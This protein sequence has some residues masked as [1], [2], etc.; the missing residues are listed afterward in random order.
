[1]RTGSVGFAAAIDA[2]ERAKGRKNRQIQPAQEYQREERNE[3]AH[4]APQRRV[5][6][7]IAGTDA[8]HLNEQLHGAAFLRGGLLA[9]G[10][11]DVP[12]KSYVASLHYR[13]QRSP[14][15]NGKATQLKQLPLMLEA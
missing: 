3:D 15:W 11:A 7:L 1:M 14:E 12:A 5:V 8:E 9:G 2:S 10:R 4:G 6:V 13:S